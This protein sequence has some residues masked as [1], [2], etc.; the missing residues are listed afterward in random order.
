M[1]P[2]KD[3]ESR[4]RAARPD[5]EAPCPPV[6]VLLARLE[7][8]RQEPRTARSQRGWRAL[9]EAI[10]AQFWAPGTGRDPARFPTVG[11]FEGATP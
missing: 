8:T 9:Y 3:I 2:L 6:S 1:S 5:V 10:A 4:L 7:R 11:R